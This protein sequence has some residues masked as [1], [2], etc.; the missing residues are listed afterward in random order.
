MSLVFDA[1][2]HTYTLDGRVLP[3][4]SEILRP[5][6]DLSAIPEHIL[7]RKS[8]IG[9]AVHYACQVIDE[10]GEFD[11]PLDPAIQGYV[12]G[13]RLFCTEHAP[14]WQ[15]IEQPTACGTFGYAGTPD[16]AG[17]LGAA[18]QCWLIDIKTVA[19]VSP[20]TGLQTAAY[21]RLLTIEGCRRAAVQLKPDGT[22][23]LEEFTSP[24]D[25]AVFTSL[26]TLHNWKAKNG[27]N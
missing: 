19:K 11:E 2:S 21:A 14:Q 8:A 20:T 16:R 6:V 13:W 1:E 7:E 25:Y 17:Y 22:Y 15:V 5:V 12:D 3:S 24:M 18:G 9:K 10:G 26:L 27:I 23:R 4:V